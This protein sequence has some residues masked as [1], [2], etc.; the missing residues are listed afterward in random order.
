MDADAFAAALPA[1]LPG[2]L[3]YARTLT[4]DTAQAED[5]VQATVVRALARSGGFRAES[6]VATWLHRILH[7]LAVDAARRSHEQPSE[8]VAEAVEAMWRKDDYTVDAAAVVARAET[9]SDLRE[10]LSHLPASYRTVVVLHDAEG[11]TVREIAEIQEVTLAAAKQRLRRAR[12]MLVS[13]LA[14][15]HERRQAL[16]GVPLLCWQARRHVSDYLDGDLAPAVAQTVEK[17][18][19]TCPTCPPLYAALVGTTNALN[20][21][22]RDPD[23]VVPPEL[24]ERLLNH[25]PGASTS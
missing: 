9:R 19:E 18:L 20:T 23:T 4:D 22:T 24:A 8:D 17:H 25:S 5:L 21:S 12:M 11:M 14:T 16:R 15:G 3:R 6:S 10:A 13:Q 2:L 7:N 1:E